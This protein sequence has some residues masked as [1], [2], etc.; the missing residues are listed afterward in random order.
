M[1]TKTMTKLEK[2]KSE[3]KKWEA[4]QRG[5]SKFG[6]CDTEPDGVFQYCLRQTVN[7]APVS[8]P[9]DA[10][11]W[12]LYTGMAG[13]NPAARRLTTSLKR[14]IAALEAVTVG[15]KSA[16]DSYLEGYLWRC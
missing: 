1:T 14:C 15:E 11:G 9:T 10:Q 2:F 7:G 12:Q 16:L 8:L 3:V 13:V 5:F 6:A 4:L